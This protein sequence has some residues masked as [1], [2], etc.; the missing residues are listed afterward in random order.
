MPNLEDIEKETSAKKELAVKELAVIEGQIKI[1]RM[2]FDDI[3]KAQDAS[4][5]GK[6]E[7][8]VVKIVIPENLEDIGKMTAFRKELDDLG[9]QKKQVLKETDGV[10]KKL[11]ETEKEN[12]RLVAGKEK[13]LYDREKEFLVRM[14]EANKRI[15]NVE[16]TL[17][18][19]TSH[20][21]E[22]LESVIAV[23]EK[24]LQNAE[25]AVKKASQLSDKAEG[26][27]KTWEMGLEDIKREREVA[28]EILKKAVA[29]EKEIARREK[30]VG[31][32]SEK[33][34]KTFKE[35]Q[36]LVFWH[37]EKGIIRQK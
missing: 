14:S 7:K 18:R 22:Y 29:K 17:K 13:F 31:E 9:E 30:E 36:E 2:E 6:P 20:A 27:S 10:L 15:G 19:A 8:N 33:A 4:R 26:L 3:L 16:E 28:D 23:A 25:M 37:K 5:N 12:Q 24:A 32:K 35:A 11:D 34:E 21:T 1:A